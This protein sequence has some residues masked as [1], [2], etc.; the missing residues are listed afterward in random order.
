MSNDGAYFLSSGEIKSMESCH[1]FFMRCGGYFGVWM[2]R[3]AR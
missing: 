1:L 3:Y 2:K